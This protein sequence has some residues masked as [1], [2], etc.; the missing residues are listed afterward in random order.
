MFGH[1]SKPSRIYKYGCKKPFYNHDIVEEQLLLAHRYRNDLVECERN[2]RQCV[3][4]ALLEL[5]PELVELEKETEAA[6]TRLEEAIATVKQAKSKARSKHG[7]TT[8]QR[9]A[10]IDARQERKALK[11]KLSALRKTYFADPKW[12]ASQNAIDDA[13]KAKRKSLRSTC[14]LYWGSYLAVEQ[15]L[16]G[17]RSGPPPKFKRFDGNGKIAVQIQKG[18]T[19]DELIAGADTRVRLEIDPEEADRKKPHGNVWIRVG[20]DGRS[21]IWTKIR[22]TIH[23][24]FPSGS[25]VKW[26]YLIRRRVACSYHWYVEFVIERELGFNLEPNQGSGRAGMDV[27]WRLLPE[28]L[29]VAYWVDDNGHH[30]EL[31]ISRRDLSRWKKVDDLCSIRDTNFNEIRLKLS[32]W[33]KRQDSVPEWL[34][35]RTEHISQWRSAARLAALTIHWRENRF[36]GDEQILT[37]LETWRKHDRHLY[38]WER[39]QHVKAVRWRDNIYRNLV[40]NLRRTYDEIIV[41]DTDWKKMQQV[42]PAEEDD[43]AWIRMY[44]RIA[45]VGRLRELLSETQNLNVTK[46]PAEYTT[47]CCYVCG[48]NE[49][50]DAASELWHTCSKCGTPW[51]QDYCAAMN[52]LNFDRQTAS[53]PVAAEQ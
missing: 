44:A 43:Q 28:G 45:S 47:Q 3:N 50:F 1:K 37:D 17:I 24:G 15:S 20:S 6:E 22:A 10:V 13:D 51:D 49:G 5:F 2:R 23:R 4:D 52:L 46:A 38:E 9:R 53:D 48:S 7:A 8:E 21:A 14:N 34:K 29:R 40:A 19:I 25:K 11:I 32:T 26:V 16:T 30:E 33:L 12:K 41:E 42:A 31:V 35:E 36:S 27:G 39:H 18:M